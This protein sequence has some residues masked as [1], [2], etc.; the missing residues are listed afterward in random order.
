MAS[1]LVPER[2]LLISPTLAATIGLEEAVLLHVIS[3]LQV[4]HP[5]TVRNQRAWFHVPDDQLARAL[6]FWQP[7]GIQHVWRSLVDKGL[8]LS[9]TGRDGRLMV[10]INQSA[11]AA[12]PPSPA[13]PLP[14]RVFD[15]P[16][17]GRAERISPDWQPDDTLYRQC[18]SQYGITADFIRERV[19]GFIMVQR[20]RGATRYSWH[21]EFLKWILKQW[22]QERSYQGARESEGRMSRQWQP[23]EDASA[24]L[25][26]AGIPHDFI[27]DCVPE[28]VLYWLEKGLIT[29]T[30]NTKFIQ[31]VRRQW[32]KYSAEVDSD[33]TP[34]L[35]AQDFEP[36]EACFDV[37][38]M[39][40]IDTNF[41][42]AQIPEFILYWQERGEASG[43]WNT[44]FLQHVKY[45]WA[46]RS[47][48][49]QPAE[50]QLES[51]IARMTD[52]SW[53]E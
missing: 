53:A 52:R 7:P 9:E 19:P 20:E 36:S 8:L 39:A 38:G 34:G 21:N 45:K 47:Q 23:S 42:R 33:N 40:N 37:L 49:L 1:S 44:R 16:Q 5:V 27:E 3:E 29:S 17:R 6:P 43:S 46:N 18:E 15:S 41:A 48:E 35:I 11:G 24:I 22:Q 10:A 12:T 25:A 2:P 14:E 26:N 28:F 51:T 13:M 31:H 32:A 4:C 30:W 50:R